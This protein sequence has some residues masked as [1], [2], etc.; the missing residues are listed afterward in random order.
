M[1]RIG[2]HHSWTYFTYYNLSQLVWKNNR[3]F[4]NTLFGQFAVDILQINHL[5]AVNNL[6]A[7]SYEV[8]YPQHGA[9]IS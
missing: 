7:D 9:Y 6:S 5:Q 8:G 2:N 3:L 4:D 1:G